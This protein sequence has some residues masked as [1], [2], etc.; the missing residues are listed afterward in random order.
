MLVMND[1]L[2]VQILFGKSCP[3]I[4]HWIKCSE[5]IVGVISRFFREKLC[6]DYVK[7]DSP[8]LEEYNWNQFYLPFGIIHNEFF[9]T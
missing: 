8:C 3:A 2:C 7:I 1:A 6:I 9:D 5:H 4:I